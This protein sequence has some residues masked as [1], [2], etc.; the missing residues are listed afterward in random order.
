MMT[1][2]NKYKK[3]NTQEGQKRLIRLI[4]VVDVEVMVWV[5]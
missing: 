3:H 2:H 1:E 4:V 5:R